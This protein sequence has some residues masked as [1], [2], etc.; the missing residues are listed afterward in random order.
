MSGTGE[1]KS[2]ASGVV[3][4]KDLAKFLEV[5]M[6]TVQALAKEGKIPQQGRNAFPFFPAV[7]AYIKHLRSLNKSN[8][9]ESGDLPRRKLKAETEEREA[10]AE[11]RKIQLEVER[12]NLFTRGEIIREWT[13]RLLEFKAAVLELPKKIAFRFADPDTRVLVEEEATSY[14][15]EILERY[16]RDGIV[17][18]GGA[19]GE[20]DDGPGATPPEENEREPVGGRK[21][22]PARKR[23]SAAGAVADE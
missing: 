4:T 23:K 17:P 16:S 21:P 14:T 11:L 8:L 20:G 6:R 12:G 5:D 10:R 13:G 15:F 18:D 7:K 2:E 1:K 9:P 19:L 22:R 3:S